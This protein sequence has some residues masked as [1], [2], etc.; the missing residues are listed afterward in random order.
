MTWNAARKP[1]LTTRKMKNHLTVGTGLR[2][3]AYTKPDWMSPQI[4]SGIANFWNCP[5]CNL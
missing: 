4:V 2:S 3:T 1:P 5:I